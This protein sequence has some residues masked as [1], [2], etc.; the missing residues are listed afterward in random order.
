M[1]AE[2]NSQ[3]DLHSLVYKGVGED[4][5]RVETPDT[6]QPKQ[7]RPGYHLRQGQQTKAE[8]PDKRTDRHRSVSASEERGGR[9]GAKQPAHCLTLNTDASRW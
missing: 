9:E 5:V 3:Q 7:P 8:C 4:T 2:L 6:I 1:C